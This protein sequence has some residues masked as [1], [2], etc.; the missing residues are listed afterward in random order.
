MNPTAKQVL[1]ILGAAALVFCTRALPKLMVREATRPA[2]KL[3]T[4]TMPVQPAM[5]IGGSDFID[6]TAA[7]TRIQRPPMSPELQKLLNRT[8]TS[9]PSAPR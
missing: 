1:S 4:F 5:V 7:M 6:R 9:S 3:P 8:P 2:P